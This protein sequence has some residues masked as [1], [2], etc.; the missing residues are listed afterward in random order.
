MTAIE[1]IKSELGIMAIAQKLNLDIDQRKGKATVNCPNCDDTGKHLT[2]YES[3]NRF[4]CYKCQVKGDQLDLY[5]LFTGNSPKTAIAELSTPGLH[6]TPATLQNPQKQ[7]TI[8]PITTNANE[9]DYS[10][11]FYGSLS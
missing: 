11:L 4:F 7:A 10:M 6:I 5:S 1:K 2:L 3:S 9:K 8:K